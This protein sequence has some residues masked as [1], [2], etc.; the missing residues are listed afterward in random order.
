[1]THISS[2]GNSTVL[3]VY[4]NIGSA[5]IEN[6]PFLIAPSIETLTKITRLFFMA[7]KRQQH[8]IMFYCYHLLT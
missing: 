1:M 2:V 4:M 5:L 8:P 7:M 6:I 3:F